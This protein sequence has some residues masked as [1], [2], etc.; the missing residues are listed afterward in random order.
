MKN[1]LGDKHYFLEFWRLESP[2][3]AQVDVPSGNGPH[4]LFTG[5]RLLAVLTWQKGESSL[6][7]PLL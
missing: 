6:E 1:R 3:K 7:G 5:G 4:F 2:I